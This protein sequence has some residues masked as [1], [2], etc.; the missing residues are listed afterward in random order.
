[1]AEYAAPVAHEGA[2]EMVAYHGDRRRLQERRL[3]DLQR[4]AIGAAIARGIFQD[5]RRGVRITAPVERA[6]GGLVARVIAQDG[7]EIARLDGTHNLAGNPIWTL[8]PSY[9]YEGRRRGITG[10]QAGSLRVAAETID[11]MIGAGA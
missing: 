5:V 3:R 4:E 9:N 11:S 8:D 10:F 2:T 1:M 6:G 7:T